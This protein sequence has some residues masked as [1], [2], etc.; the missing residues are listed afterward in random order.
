VGSQKIVG[1]R[2]R[3]NQQELNNALQEQLKS[4]HKSCESFDD[5]GE[6]SEA[7]HIAV[8]LRIL[9]HSKGQSKGLVSQ[10]NLG[11]DV[12]DTAFIVPPSFTTVGVPAPSSDER[13]LI[14]IGGNKAYVP[15]F[16]N[17]PAGIYKT[18]FIQWWEGNVL[19]DSE[20]HKFT[21]KSLVLNVA[22]TDGGAHVDPTLDSDYYSLTRKGSFGVVRVVPTKDPK[23]FKRVETPSPVAVTLRQIGHETLKTLCPGY[24]YNGR[25]YYQG[26]ALCYISAVITPS[27]NQPNNK[28]L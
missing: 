18:P 25:G 8:S 7:N 20:G 12:F 26:G 28:Q 5:Q 23:I 2:I 10:L 24:N 27:T 11:D 13:R 4:L 1:K 15:L 21:R 16:D 17:G 14:A 6:V 3:L 22:D 19:S 9:W